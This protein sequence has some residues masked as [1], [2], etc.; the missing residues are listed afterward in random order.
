MAGLRFKLSINPIYVPS[1]LLLIV[2]WALFKMTNPAL[3]REATVLNVI[4][5]PV[6]A[7]QL[8]PSP[9]KIESY[10]ACVHLRCVGSP[11]K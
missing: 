4:A 7:D 11:K 1:N 9:R 3:A 8:K 2:D 10:S 5:P 6:S